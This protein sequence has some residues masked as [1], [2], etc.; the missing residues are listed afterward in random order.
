MRFDPR[1]RPRAFAE[2]ADQ[3]TGARADAA[4]ASSPVIP[5]DERLAPEMRL[6]IVS[7]ADGA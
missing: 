1:Y 6:V 2:L 7:G 5:S 3:V 4:R